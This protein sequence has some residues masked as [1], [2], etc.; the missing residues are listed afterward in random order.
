MR[1]CNEELIINMVILLLTEVVKMPVD[2]KDEG[3]KRGRSDIEGMRFSMWNLLIEMGVGV[4]IKPREETSY[5]VRR[6]VF[7]NCV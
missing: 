4:E 5:M 1:C 2:E 6:V 3:R 7:L